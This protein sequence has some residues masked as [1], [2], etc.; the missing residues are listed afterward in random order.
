MAS[1]PWGSSVSQYS[2]GNPGVNSCMSPQGNHVPNGS[3]MGVQS[4]CAVSMNPASLPS[5]AQ[6]SHMMMT[7]CQAA[8]DPLFGH[9]DTE[10]RSSS[11]ATL[12]L[13]AR[14]HSAAMELFSTSPY[15]K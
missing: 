7:S 14:E 15:A 8:I 6:A 12:R 9:V 11:I 1:T 10:R 2:G 5:P 3:F 4:Q 13:K